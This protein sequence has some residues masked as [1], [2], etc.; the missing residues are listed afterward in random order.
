MSKLDEY[1]AKV[2]QTL[3][4]ASHYVPEAS[5]SDAHTL[6]EHGEPAE[7]VCYIAWAIANAG[8]RVPRELIL[9][10]YEL[11]EGLVSDEDLPPDLWQLASDAEELSE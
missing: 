2:R 1:L 4:F 5:L 10:I 3:T 11:T 6:I 8:V 7:G 9:S